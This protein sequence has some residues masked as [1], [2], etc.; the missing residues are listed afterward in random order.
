MVSRHLNGDEPKFLSYLASELIGKY[1]S[2][3]EKLLV[4]LPGKR[5]RLF[6]YRAWAA[7]VGAPVWAPD[8][9]TM[10]E[11]VFKT[12]SL[13]QA[14]EIM[15]SLALWEICGKTPDFQI[16]FEQFTGWAP[17]ILRDF[18]Q[19]DLFLA[20]P[21]QVFINLYE[22]RELSLWSPDKSQSLSDFEKQYIAFYRKIL[23]WYHQ[24]R[25]LM[26][27]Q[28]YAWQGLAFRELADNP[29][30]LLDTYRDRK[31]VFAG[32][33]AFTPSEQRIVQTLL[34][35]G[36]AE[37]IWDADT[38]YLDDEKQEAGHFIR[39]WLK[40]NP[41][42][43]F[44][45]KTDVLAS[46]V[47]KITVYGVH[48]IRGQARM[49]GQLLG[50]VEKC[51]PDT[52]VVLSDESLLLPMLNAIPGNITGFN[53]TMGLS[54]RHTPALSWLQ[55]NLQL[56]H[57]K[58]GGRGAWMRL[59]HLQSLVFHPWFRLLMED[60]SGEASQGDML[61]GLKRR[62]LQTEE[63]TGHFA[64]VFPKAAGY[65]EAF[66][67]PIASPV[68]F[69][70]KMDQ[71]ARRLLKNPAVSSYSFYQ[72]AL[73]EILRILKTITGTILNAT[74]NEEGFAMMYF[75]LNRLIH[76]A[77]IPFT[78]EPLEGIQ[79]LGLLET[80]NLDFRH[81]II[82]S[83]NE[84]ILPA[85]RKHNSLIPNDIRKYHGLPGWQY[86]DALYAYHFFHL[87]QQASTI[88]IIY[89]NDL[90]SDFTGEMSR[91]IRQI[92]SELVTANPSLTYAHHV[93]LDKILQTRDKPQ[94]SIE[95]TDLVYEALIWQLTN[96]GLS[97]SQIRNYVRCPLMFYFGFVAGIDEMAIL[98][99]SLDARELGNL[100]HE[101]LMQIYVPGGHAKTYD[102]KG[103]KI[104]PEPFTPDDAFFA[105]ALKQCDEIVE[106]HMLEMLGGSGPIT[107]KN[108]IILDVARFMVRKFLEN[109]RQDIKEH[110][111]E[112]LDVERS[113]K[114][115]L[116]MTVGDRVLDVKIIGFA[117]RIDRYDGI[118]RISDYKTGSMK[119]VPLTWN[120]PEEIF[121]L[122][123]Y[124]KVL[125]LLLYCWIYAGLE[126][127]YNINAGIY[128]LKSPTDYYLDLQGLQGKS[129]EEIK[130]VLKDFQ[131]A[132]E[133]FCFILLD[134]NIP[135][136][137]TED[138]TMC[139][140]CPYHPVCL[141]AI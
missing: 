73:I 76:G 103:G 46:G 40:D 123:K 81:V 126:N 113:L 48:G 133:Q 35:A 62:F 36:Q 51:D 98:D 43:E 10:E 64:D 85:G 72:G 21:E 75:M 90:A 53:V 94:V 83:V 47:K 117:D 77:S 33:N 82:L 99:E 42:K 5:A 32:F 3:S 110:Q 59:I 65:V 80:R 131:T 108:L 136:R 1:G 71:A 140:I 135:F 38:W 24:L 41:V 39:Q 55:L 87:M 9:L 63:V 91:F 12:H 23:P 105:G 79:I 104:L 34:R 128:A 54:L 92:E 141:T 127:D 112:M 49:A 118:T 122:P 15:L 138:T 109:E 28:G 60:P 74:N 27:K 102:R 31:V 129:Q 93:V 44:G 120:A 50:G 132:L 106:G 58:G 22:A 6:L 70:D 78:G 139:E 96:R 69:I 4:I 2:A 107:G 119:D 114:T 7:E 100:V 26:L 19:V 16:S 111:L 88:D 95:K 20:A 89:N 125:Q 67:S 11:F 37:L 8:V 52:A 17:V 29:G 121:S 14:D 137:Q 115:A 84:R 101:S 13:Q 86:Q 134:R 130:A 56:F 97:P 57:R 61:A 30:R 25:E 45:R 124:D 68:E 18:N 66:F 116:K